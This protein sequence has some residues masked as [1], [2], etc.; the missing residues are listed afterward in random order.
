MSIGDPRRFA[1]TVSGSQ[2]FAWYDTSGNL[3]ATCGNSTSAATSTTLPVVG[4]TAPVPVG[5]YFVVYPSNSTSGTGLSAMR[6]PGG[7]TN[8]GFIRIGN[9]SPNEWV[10][11][12]LNTSTE[13]TGGS[14]L[15]II[16][17]PTNKETPLY[18]IP[19]WSEVQNMGSQTYTTILNS[20]TTMALSSGGSGS[21]AARFTF[22]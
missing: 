11:Y 13:F 10:Y 19:T 8:T 9:S 20:Y 21:G 17:T 1:S 16:Y 12:F 5:S 6:H 22:V 14:S 3:I 15:P 7:L 18:A 4:V 2:T